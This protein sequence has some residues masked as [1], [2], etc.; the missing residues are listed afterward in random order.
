MPGIAIRARL[1]LHEQILPSFE[2]VT[3]AALLA[4]QNPAGRGRSSVVEKTNI[5]NFA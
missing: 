1:L 5:V 3:S 4:A 2:T